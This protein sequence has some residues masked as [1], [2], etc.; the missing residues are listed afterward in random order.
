[1]V[2]NDRAAV[3][4]TTKLTS[5][6]SSKSAWKRGFRPFKVSIWLPH[7]SLGFTTMTYQSTSKKYGG[8]FTAVANHS[9]S[10]YAGIRTSPAQWRVFSSLVVRSTLIHP[11]VTT[12]TM[13]GSSGHVKTWCL[14]SRVLECLFCIPTGSTHSV[15]SFLNLRAQFP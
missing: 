15:P 10:L 14:H 2:Q 8:P 5:A 1:M 9:I 12:R 13:T 6:P 4:R 11:C 3:P 7:A